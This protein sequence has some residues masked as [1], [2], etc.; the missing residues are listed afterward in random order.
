MRRRPVSLLVFTAVLLLM[1]WLMP[2]VLLLIFSGVLLAV[3]LRGGGDLAFKRFG[4]GG[5]ARVLLFALLVVLAIVGFG[6]LAAAPLAEQASQLWQQ[7]P[8]MTQQITSRLES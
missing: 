2:S 8:R 7:V 4:L 5:T 3:F 1:L 6:M